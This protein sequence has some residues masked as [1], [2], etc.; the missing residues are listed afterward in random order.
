MDKR[1]SEL[2]E[3]ERALRK[4]NEYTDTLY[5]DLGTYLFENRGKQL[6]GTPYSVIL[7]NIRSQLSESRKISGEIKSLRENEEK[8]EELKKEIQNIDS[9]QKEIDKTIPGLFEDI[10]SLA[11]SL[12]TKNN[13]SF[14]E[15]ETHFFELKSYDDEIVTIEETIRKTEE[16]EKA[17]P[18]LEKIAGRGQKALLLGKKLLK[19]RSLSG[20]CRSLGENLYTAGYFN[21]AP[22][23]ELSAMY[24]ELKK[25]QKEVNRLAAAAAQKE[26]EVEKLELVLQE[27]I[28]GKRT[29]KKISEL[30]KSIDEAEHT[31]FDSYRE[32]G[33]ACYEKHPESIQNDKEVKQL[34]GEIRNNVTQ[35]DTHAG[36]IVR[37]TEEI[38]Y[39]KLS[40]KIEIKKRSIASC[41]SGIEKYQLKIDV[42]ERE[43]DVLEQEQKKL[44][45]A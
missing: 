39:L 19:A 32:L 26:N 44:S 10:G 37:L 34:Y 25:K 38:E 24:E 16:V 43:I 27:Q 41:K 18:L 7:K 35:M 6:T 22:L 8:L 3:H 5:L 2:L 12:Y 1:K 20:Y 29:G 33:I 14:E 4:L 9:R 15:Y 28:E 11:Y 30:E 40:E 13:A 23:P 45:K 21:N 36:E 31:V 17:R 42:L